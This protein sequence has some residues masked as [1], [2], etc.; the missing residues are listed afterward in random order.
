[1][2]WLLLILAFAVSIAQAQTYRSFGLIIEN[3][4]KEQLVIQAYSA[5]RGHWKPG[6]MPEAGQTIGID[7]VSSPYVTESG[8]IGIGVAGMLYLQTSDGGL[9]S[10]NW[11]MPWAGPA[12]YHAHTYSNYIKIHSR[13]NQSD[14]TNLVWL[15]TISSDN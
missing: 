4:T 12:N 9:I 6:T 14:P 15:I 1:M 8:M 11:N 7:Q 13:L 10:L 3:E 5:L 2:R